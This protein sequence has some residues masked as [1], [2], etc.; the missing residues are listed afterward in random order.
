METAKRKALYKSPFYRKK[1]FEICRVNDIK[2]LIA[3]RILFMLIHTQNPSS[4]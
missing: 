4:A 3:Y 2:Q 1:S